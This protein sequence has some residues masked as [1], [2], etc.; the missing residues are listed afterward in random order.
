MKQYAAA[1]VSA[2]EAKKWSYIGI[3]LGLAIGII[4][5]FIGFVGVFSHNL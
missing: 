4:Y 3:G 2:E 1:Q 5:L